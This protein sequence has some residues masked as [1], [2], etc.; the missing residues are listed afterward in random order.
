[1][2]WRIFPR[3]SKKRFGSTYARKKETK[4]T[5]QKTTRATPKI[6]N[7]HFQQWWPISTCGHYFAMLTLRP[8]G[9]SNVVAR[10]FFM[11]VQ[12]PL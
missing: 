5:S 1:L 3:N 9:F 7:F 6:A 8:P 10:G 11:R 12:L 4:K 2:H